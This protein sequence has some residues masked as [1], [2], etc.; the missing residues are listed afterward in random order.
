ME[1]REA[2]LNLEG[3]EGE[4]GVESFLSLFFCR[5][6]KALQAHFETLDV[7]ALV[8]LSEWDDPAMQPLKEALCSGKS[9][10]PWAFSFLAWVHDIDDDQAFQIT[11]QEFE[12]LRTVATAFYNSPLAVRYLPFDPPV[13]YVPTPVVEVEPVSPETEP[14][15]EDPEEPVEEP[16]E[17][18]ITDAPAA[19][20]PEPAE[21]KE[22]RFEVP[23]D[24]EDGITLSFPEAPASPLDKRNQLMVKNKYLGYGKNS[25]GVMGLCGQLKIFYFNEKSLTGR[26]ESSNPLLFME[27]RRLSGQSTTVTYWLPP[28][29]FPHP[30]GQIT[31][32]TEKDTRTLS[33]YSLFP[34]S[35]T[36]YWRNRTV[37]SALLAPALIGFLYFAFVYLLTAVELNEAAQT[38]FPE[39]YE[40]TLAGVPGTDFRGQGLGLYRLRVVPAGESLQMI[41]A[42]VVLLGPLLSSK[43]YHYLSRSRKRKFMPLLATALLLPTMLLL[44]GWNFQGEVFPL[45][46][47]PD[48]APLDLRGFLI[49]SVPMNS[50]VAGYLFFSTQ[51]FLDRWIKARELRLALPILSVVAYLVI[52]FILIYGRSWIDF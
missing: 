27:P 1:E 29:A 7:D 5:L 42:T 31:I 12:E 23:D 37:A 19:P 24:P 20:E 8:A 25:E 16:P 3:V 30:A 35:R 52:M 4:K 34:K 14:E 36:D 38:V 10:A 2:L 33:L 44:V 46:F 45:F 21:S 9:M 39:Q 50:L 17:E 47:H 40:E 26:V 51:G 18:P 28:V 41:W 15:S 49:W 13:E 43:I 32:R 48:F 22:D 11:A 6:Q